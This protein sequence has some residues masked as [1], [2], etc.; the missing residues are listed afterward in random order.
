MDLR[1]TWRRAEVAT[2]EPAFPDAGYDVVFEDP[3]SGA[4][5]GVSVWDDGGVEAIALW[6]PLV[7]PG[8]RPVSGRWEPT[9]T[10]AGE[11]ALAMWSADSATLPTR[12][13]SFLSH[14]GRRYRVAYSAADGGT[15]IGEF[16][17]ALVSL[18]FGSAD[19]ADLVAPL[20]QP[21]PRTFS[22][23]PQPTP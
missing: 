18:E 2:T 13:A 5:L 10:V 22:A 3:A 16:V 7:A 19:T 14:A 17:R 20:P 9:D 8:M 1:D 15:L 23:G 4:R 11:P 21:T 6:V 12:Y